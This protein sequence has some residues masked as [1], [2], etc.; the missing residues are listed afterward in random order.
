M[1]SV[2]RAHANFLYSAWNIFSTFFRM[3][4]FYLLQDLF[5]FY[6]SLIFFFFVCLLRVFSVK[7]KSLLFFHYYESTAAMSESILKILYI[8]TFFYD[9]AYETFFRRRSF[10]T[11]RIHFYLIRPWC[12]F[13]YLIHKGFCVV[14]EF[15]SIP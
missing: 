3:K 11:K 12:I 4:L 15:A 14:H 10:E 13:F 1:F 7:S 9:K 8:F 6:F 2:T 5:L